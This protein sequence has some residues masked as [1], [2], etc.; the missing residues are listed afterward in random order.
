MGRSPL[1][2]AV[3]ATLAVTLS[4]QWIAAKLGV[5]AVPPLELST[6]RFAIAAGVRLAARRAHA[7]LPEHS[8]GATGTS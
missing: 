2:I 6:M 1:I 4:G 3:Y 7:A 5:T 8:L